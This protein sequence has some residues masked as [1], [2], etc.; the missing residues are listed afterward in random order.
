MNKLQTV[1]PRMIKIIEVLTIG[2]GIEPVKGSIIADYP[3]W[4]IL[5]DAQTDTHIA[6]MDMEHLTKEASIHIH[7]CSKSDIEE[8]GIYELLFL[9]N[10]NVYVKVEKELHEDQKVA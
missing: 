5:C 4:V 2:L 7:T 3:T 10:K 9:N 1:L 6:L 8:G